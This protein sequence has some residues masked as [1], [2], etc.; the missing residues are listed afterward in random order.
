MLRVHCGNKESGNRI[1]KGER[2]MEPPSDLRLGS[3]GARYSQ[4]IVDRSVCWMGF[5]GHEYVPTRQG[6][7]PVHERLGMIK[8][9]TLCRNA[10][11]LEHRAPDGLPTPPRWLIF[12]IAGTADIEWFLESGRIT[13]RCA[14]FAESLEER[15]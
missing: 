14:T 15:R 8:P 3:H 12:Q 2:K 13:F 4:L 11:Y 5:G 9:W 6:C 1:H 7:V 10:R